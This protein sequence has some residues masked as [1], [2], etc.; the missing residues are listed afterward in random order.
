MS[1]FGT[2]P[3][4]IKMAPVIKAI[5]ANAD[6]QSVVVVTGQHREM[7]QQVLQIFEI[8]PNYDLDIMEKNQSLAKI[9]SKVILGLDTIL[10]K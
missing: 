2:R 1:I 5:E 7:L 4:A 8:E 10:E 9:T 3:E 6:T